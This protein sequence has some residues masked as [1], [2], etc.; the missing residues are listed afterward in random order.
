[1]T[2]P[3]PPKA[4]ERSAVQSQCSW[5][6]PGYEHEWREDVVSESGHVCIY[7]GT[8]MPEDWPEEDDRTWHE[9]TGRA[10]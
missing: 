9:R 6:R 1:M 4:P 10:V 5:D 7:C 2:D 3:I 8:P